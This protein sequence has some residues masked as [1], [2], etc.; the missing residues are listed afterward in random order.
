MRHSAASAGGNVAT[1]HAAIDDKV[2]PIALFG[3][4]NTN[5]ADG[6]NSSAEDMAK[7]ES[8]EAFDLIAFHLLDP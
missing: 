8:G 4:D 7:M 5:P 3:S 6:I 2:R 1:P